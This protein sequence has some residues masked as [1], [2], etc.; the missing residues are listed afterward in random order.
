M[1][2]ELICPSCHI[3]LREDQMV[4]GL[5]AVETCPHCQSLLE[6]EERKI[7]TREDLALIAAWLEACLTSP[8]LPQF[9]E[10]QQGFGIYRWSAKATPVESNEPFAWEIEYRPETAA[11]LAVRCTKQLIGSHTA[12]EIP[13]LE[14]I[15][16]E[17]G[18]QPYR[19]QGV[20]PS[21][22]GALE[23]VVEWGAS[24]Y[25]STQSLSPGLLGAVAE[26]L[27]MVVREAFVR[28]EKR[29]AG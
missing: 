29:V 24:Q 13:P 18:V 11:V 21:G 7:R 25:L 5:W 14:T 22:W 3:A 23:R 2:Q 20:L 1:S 28:S 9:V 12:G 19:R 4:P 26:R 8:A 27:A 15:C 10:G 6:K 17:H 16:A